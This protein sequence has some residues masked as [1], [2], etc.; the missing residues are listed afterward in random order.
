M[1]L[2]MG[3]PERYIMFP[4]GCLFKKEYLLNNPDIS[5]HGFVSKILE[6]HAVTMSTFIEQTDHRKRRK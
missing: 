3:I 4:V 5:A 6:N 2:M 1:C